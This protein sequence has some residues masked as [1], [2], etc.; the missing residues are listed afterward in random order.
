MKE[1]IFFFSQ[2]LC[3]WFNYNK[4]NFSFRE[5]KEPYFVWISEIM[6]QQTRLGYVINLREDKFKKFIERFPDLETLANSTE[7][8][9]LYYWSGL[10]YYNRAKNLLRTARIIYYEKNSQFPQNYEEL[11]HLPG[12]GDY[13]ASAIL[14]MCFNQPYAVVDG[15]VKRVLL[16]F[17]YNHLKN[18]LQKIHSFAN[19]ILV[20]SHQPPSLYNEA[21]ME[22]GSTICVPKYPKCHQ[23]FLKENCDAKNSIQE[24]DKI[25]VKK[26]KKEI[27]ILK[28]YIVTRN[29][30]VLIIR[31]QKLFLKGHYFF[32]YEIFSHNSEKMNFNL[33]EDDSS[34]YIGNIK[35][36]IMHY[37]FDCYIFEKTE[38][39]LRNRSEEF[40]WMPIKEKDKYLIHN[41]SK[42][43]MNK[44][45][46]NQKDLF[47]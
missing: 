33:K 30:D 26:K 25:L 9:V 11:I 41:L 24:V 7:E 5:K 40:L 34:F 10:G 45:L 4:R 32:P 19:T 13:T 27:L 12:I 44:W 15:N 35:H 23:C 3:K 39:S 21:I 8:E 46:E 37:Q 47:T 22:F 16:R 38:K 43:I 28:V 6:L 36:N 42:K 29:Q 14:S 20:H 18:D 31:N 1:K 2:E 17:F